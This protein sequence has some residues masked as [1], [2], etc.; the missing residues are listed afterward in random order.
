MKLEFIS[1]CCKAPVYTDY[2]F[3]IDVCCNCFFP[4]EVIEKK[5]VEFVDPNQLKLFEDDNTRR[6]NKTT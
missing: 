5:E 4:C 6:D 1:D 3:D 2:E